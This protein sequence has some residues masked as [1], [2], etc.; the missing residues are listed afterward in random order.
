MSYWAKPR[1]RPCDIA[2]IKRM[3]TTV[4]ETPISETEHNCNP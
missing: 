3:M 2:T 4:N 1:N